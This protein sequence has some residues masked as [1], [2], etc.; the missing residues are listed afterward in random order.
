MSPVPPSRSCQYSQSRQLRRE[1]P[2][3]VHTL[4]AAE[5]PALGRPS[6]QHVHMNP[7]T[8]T[9]PHAAVTSVHPPSNAQSTQGGDHS[10]PE[11]Q[12]SLVPGGLCANWVCLSG[13]VFLSSDRLSAETHSLGVVQLVGEFEMKIVFKTSHLKRKE[14]FSEPIN[15]RE[16]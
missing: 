9:Q 16:L 2:P 1:H 5:T 11:S 14:P 4:S 12:S 10:L 6:R 13:R 15:K 8:H 3:L 7:H